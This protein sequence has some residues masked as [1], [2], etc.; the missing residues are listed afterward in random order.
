MSCILSLLCAPCVMRNLC[1]KCVQ[2]CL[3]HD[4]GAARLGPSWWLLVT[5]TYLGSTRAYGWW[6]SMY[7]SHQ[8][9]YGAPGLCRDC[10]LPV[11]KFEC[12]SVMLGMQ[13]VS[14]SQQTTLRVDLS[15]YRVHRL[16]SWYLLAVSNVARAWSGSLKCSTSHT[17]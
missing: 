8:L 2:G 1:C 12:P 15:D 7:T 17:E 5:G 13:H 11:S 14:W 16:A 6:G 9:C 3:V 4:C 10:P